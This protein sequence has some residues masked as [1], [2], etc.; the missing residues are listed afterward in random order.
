MDLGFAA[1]TSVQGVEAGWVGR[2]K[3]R[4]LS[5][6]AADLLTGAA[7][8]SDLN[9][10]VILDD[11][12]AMAFRCEWNSVALDP[13]TWA[14]QLDGLDLVFIESAW[15]GNDRLWRGKIA[16][17]GGPS[18]QFTRLLA[19]CKAQ[20]IPSVFWNKEDPPHY[21]DFLPAARLFDVVFTSD[22]GRIERYRAD[23]GHD[24]IDV[25]PFAAQPAVHNPVR[26]SKGW[27]QRDVAFGGMYFA[28]KY[29][30]RRAQMDL[31]LN[32]V[33]DA[34]S[35]MNT[36]LEIFS[37]QLGGNPDYQFPAPL[38]T[39]VVG[40]LTYPQMLSAYKAYKVFLNVNSVVGSASMCA[41]RIFEISAAGTP[42]IS[43]PSAA[44]R[45]FFTADEVPVAESR[46]DAAH[47]SRAL[48]KNP[49]LN[50][51]TAH[52]AQRRIWQEHTYAHR[53]E[54]VLARALPGQI[55]GMKRPT[56]SALVPTIRPQQVE[57]VFRTIAAQ[58]GISTQLVL[59]THGFE[60]KHD[61]LRYLQEHYGLADVSLLTAGRDMSLGECLNRCVAAADGD[62]L[63]KIDDDDHYGSAYLSDQ[64]FAL[65]FSR[66]EVVGK[67]A[68]YMHLQASQ[69]TI[70]RFGQKEH[71]YTDFVMGPT[72]VAR[73]ETFVANPF[74]AIGLGED[75]GFLRNA[76]LAGM[77]IYSADRFNF[78]QVRAGDGHTWQVDDAELLASGELKFYGEPNEHTDI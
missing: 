67:Q 57:G 29:P 23:L 7:R 50:D 17:E 59:L 62:V 8:R 74:P 46:K 27:H 24:R 76:G 45:N 16:G 77:Q 61:E 31:L 34:S 35:K 44:I 68:H 43:A 58:K 71:R 11:F 14:Q 5:F 30:E 72:I 13:A 39:R 54:S 70:L 66:A 28:H 49:E 37:R 52:L 25:L 41:R 47:L 18:Q 55:S 19:A 38:D 12:S 75:T 69:A 26:P 73:K 78:Y 36:G 10:G 40:S 21:D 53:V 33:M 22:E 48:V 3:K 65:D 20:G 9:V 64:L 32:G 1:P 60:L 2:G 6:A 42:V 63:A 15:A 56:A 51:R 4:H